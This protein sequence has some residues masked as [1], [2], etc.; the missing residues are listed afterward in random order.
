MRAADLERRRLLGSLVAAGGAACALARL[1]ASPVSA[2]GV[3]A[4]PSLPVPSAGDLPARPARWFKKLDGLR[5][6][7]G[8]CP[9]KCRVADMERGACGV[10]ENR[11]GEYFTLVHSRP[12]SLHLDPVE[13]KPFYHVLPGTSAVSL[14]TVG[15]NFECKFCQNWEIAQAR[16]EQVPAIDAPPERLV[17]LAKAN[18][19]PTIACTYTEPV[20]W[21]EYVY[22]IAAAG[23]KAGIRTLMISNGSIQPEPMG[24]LLDVLAA[25]KVDLKA[26]TD[27][28]YRV[29]CKGELKPV[30]D[31][32]RLLKKKGMWTEI[33]VLI[34]PTLND[35]EQEHRELARFVAGDLGPDV[36]VHF[37]RFH[38]G[39]RL[40]NLPSTP[41]P[42]L[43]RAREIAMTEGL[44]F[45]YVGNVP[46]HPG[47][48]T[49]CPGCKTALI[50]RTGLAVTRNRLVRGRCPD[51][52]R[53]VPGIWA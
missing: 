1:G 28:F 38:P 30:L 46:G 49:Y 13:K 33:V 7:C 31:T 39:Y 10:R 17:A 3:D 8:L 16:P 42:V 5:V 25:V 27:R 37:T 51:C 32:L 22:D 18:G 21:S 4:G 35:G 53:E 14:A 36:P 11:G 44:H 34:V 52:G 20:V 48:H 15:C 41:V 6:E 12:C 45:A 9:R 43:E 40:M 23:R 24:D 2:Q 50:E 47:N 19:T 26:Y 29:T